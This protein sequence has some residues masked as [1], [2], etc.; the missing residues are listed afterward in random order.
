MSQAPIHV[1][2]NNIND[3]LQKLGEL[4]RQ[5]HDEINEDWRKKF[6]KKVAEMTNEMELAVEATKAKK[7]CANCKKEVVVDGGVDP[8]ACSLRCLKK[9]AFKIM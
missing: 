6:E 7:W 5:K 8:P 3:T 9:I 4:V 2:S 1:D